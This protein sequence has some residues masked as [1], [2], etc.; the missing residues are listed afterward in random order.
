MRGLPGWV[1][2]DHAEDEILNYLGSPLVVAGEL[3]IRA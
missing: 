2:S 3:S 1:L